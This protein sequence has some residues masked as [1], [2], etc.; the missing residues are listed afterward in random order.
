[1]T[2]QKFGSRWLD[3]ANR[4][5]TTCRKCGLPKLR[6]DMRRDPDGLMTCASCAADDFAKQRGTGTLIVLK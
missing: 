3:E 5:V 6:Q 4:M 2:V 1:M